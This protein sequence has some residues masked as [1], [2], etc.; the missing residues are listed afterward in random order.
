M[1]FEVWVFAN[2]QFKKEDFNAKDFWNKQNEM[3]SPVVIVYDNNKK[4][5]AEGFAIVAKDIKDLGQMYENK[6]F[7]TSSIPVNEYQYKYG[8]IFYG[9]EPEYWKWEGKES[10]EIKL[11]TA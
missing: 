5:V 7:Y 4:E 8:A 2:S 3:N 1:D 10:E 6:I 11:V 9:V